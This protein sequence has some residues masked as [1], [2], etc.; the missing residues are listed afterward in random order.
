MHTVCA[1]TCMYMYILYTQ[2]M[3]S[4]VSFSPVSSHVLKV[5]KNRFTFQDKD[6]EVRLPVCSRKQNHSVHCTNVEI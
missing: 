4:L 1:C 6:P 2:N 3:Y 5:K